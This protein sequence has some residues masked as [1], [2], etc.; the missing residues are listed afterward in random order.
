[1]II[2]I[3]YYFLK[4]CFE[5]GWRVYVGNVP[6]SHVSVRH[7]YGSADR[8]KD[9]PHALT[10]TNLAPSYTAPDGKEYRAGDVDHWNLWW[11]LGAPNSAYNRQLKPWQVSKLVQK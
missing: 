6:L 2:R 4:V 3:R 11:R 10:A 9:M 1:M 7:P 5:R 8:H